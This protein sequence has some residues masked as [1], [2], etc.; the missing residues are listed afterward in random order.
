NKNEVW[1]G[2]IGGLDRLDKHTGNWRHYLPGSTIQSIFFDSKGELWVGSDRNLYRYKKNSD[3]FQLYVDSST[4]TKPG[5]V[6][7]IIEDLDHNLWVTSTD[8][9]YRINSNRNAL[10]VLGSKHGIHR[11]GLLYA[12]NLL[13]KDGRLFLGDD[14]GYYNF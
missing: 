13:T 3:D 9:I 5:V 8:N 12:S 11:N 1:I 7:N 4:G 6:L 10:V 2:T 14:F